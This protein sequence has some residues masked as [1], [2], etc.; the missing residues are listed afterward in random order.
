MTRPFDCHDCR[1]HGPKVGGRTTCEAE[2]DEALVQ[3]LERVGE[4]VD[5]EG[6]PRMLARCPRRVAER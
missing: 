1:Y 4:R 6:V 5:R 2:T 3:W